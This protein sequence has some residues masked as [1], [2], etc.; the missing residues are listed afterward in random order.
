[1]LIDED[2][3]YQSIK[4]RHIDFALVELFKTSQGFRQWFTSQLELESEIAEFQGVRRSTWIHAGES[5]LEVGFTTTNTENLIILIENKIG[6]SKQ[7]RQ[8]ER[9]H[10]RGGFYTTNGP[11]DRFIVCLIAPEE[12][13]SDTDRE[14]FG[15]TIYY[16]DILRHLE[17]STH[18]GTPY[19]RYLFKEGTR[20]QRADGEFSDLTKEIA[21]GALSRVNDDFEIEAHHVTGK[22]IRLESRNPA[23]PTFI[24]FNAYIPGG[25]DGDK[26][27]VRINPEEIGGYDNFLTELREVVSNH[28][29]TL[30]GFE[31]G[32]NDSAMIRST[33][34]RSEFD[35]Q[36]EY[37]KAIA[38]K[39]T[40]LIRHYHAILETELPV[41]EAT[42]DSTENSQEND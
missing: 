32:N 4:E 41:S 1:M 33:V 39:L 6:A 31:E 26:A 2:E 25:A 15:N 21:E 7:E 9:Y 8:A 29:D 38:T 40:D 28:V 17:S 5:D 18:D 30:P 19:F 23:V 22:Q 37:I 42:P 35:D 12:Y 13:V 3:T 20:R 11:W 16:E 27:I 34:Y 14:E 24:K 36:D 10:E